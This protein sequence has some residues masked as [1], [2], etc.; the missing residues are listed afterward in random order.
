MY[1]NLLEYNIMNKKQIIEIAIGDQP[2]SKKQ[3]G[4]TLIELS[5]VLVIIGLIVGGILVGQDLIKAAEIRATVAQIEKYNSAVNTFRTKFNGLPGDL[6]V[7]KATAFGLYS[8]AGSA[9][10]GD[11]NGLIDGIVAGTSAQYAW[12]QECGIFWYHLSQANLID[13]NLAVYAWDAASPVAVAS[14]SLPSTFPIAKLGRGNYVAAGSASGFNY[15]W[16]TGVNSGLAT[17]GLVSSPNI[18]PIEAYNMDIK[19]DDGNPQTGVVQVHGTGTISATSSSLTGFTDNT[20]ASAASVAGYCDVGSNVS[21]DTYNRSIT[22]GGS[23]QACS[24]RFRFN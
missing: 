17:G 1:L 7:N 10:R 20:S 19:L 8:A 14:A 13:G 2:K 12:C 3:K 15:F 6:D 16:I 4:F 9:G 22:S 11:N 24:V 23:T 5:I 21:S 18:T